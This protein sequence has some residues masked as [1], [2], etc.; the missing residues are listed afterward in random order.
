[1]GRF[2]Y[3]KITITK[4][5]LFFK[6]HK[7]NIHFNLST[8]GTEP[9]IVDQ[10]ILNYIKAISDQAIQKLTINVLSTKKLDKKM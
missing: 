10:G 1:M 5:T 3:S 7:P 4:Q 9:G 6:D 8:F 2:I